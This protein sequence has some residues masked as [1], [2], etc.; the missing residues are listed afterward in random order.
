MRIGSLYRIHSLGSDG[1]ARPKGFEFA[2]LPHPNN[3][4]EAPFPGSSF[5]GLEGD[6]WPK[7]II[8]III[9]IIIDFTLEINSIFFFDSNNIYFKFNNINEYNNI[10]NI[11]KNIKLAWPKFL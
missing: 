5:L 1:A 10:Y 4:G 9:T 3:L 2:H 7:L 8:I 11:N 6:A